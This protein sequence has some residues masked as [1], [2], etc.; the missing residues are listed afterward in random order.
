MHRLFTPLLSLPL[1]FAA[2]AM[3]AAAQQMPDAQ[4][5]KPVIGACQA[6]LKNYSVDELADILRSEGYGA[7]KK[8]NDTLLSFKASGEPMGLALT[9]NQD[10]VLLFI[11]SRQALP[12]SAVNEWNYTRV[13]TKLHVSKRGS[14]VLRL[15]LPNVGRA[16]YRDKAIKSA[17][18]FFARSQVPAFIRFYMK[19]RKAAQ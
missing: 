4:L 7:V 2:S 9:K 18:R 12:L 14:N 1:L 16:G 8:L 15:V 17:V 13:Y 3:H 6:C 10:I 5:A 11:V 19:A